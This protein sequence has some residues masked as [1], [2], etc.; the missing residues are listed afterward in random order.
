MNLNGLPKTS[1][2]YF[3]ISTTDLTIFSNILADINFNS[4]TEIVS[5]PCHNFIK[6]TILLRI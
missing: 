4:S 5:L 1:V 3:S 2:I 6:S